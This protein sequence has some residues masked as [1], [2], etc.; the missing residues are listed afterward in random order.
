MTRRE[1][2]R[3]YNRY[4]SDVEQERNGRPIPGEI[5]ALMTKEKDPDELWQLMVFDREARVL[6]PMG[7]MMS[8]DAIGQMAEAVNRQIATGQRQDWTKAEAYPMTPISQG[9]Y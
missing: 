5:R 7:P 8:K 3:L 2:R 6:V 4:L 9:A 1:K